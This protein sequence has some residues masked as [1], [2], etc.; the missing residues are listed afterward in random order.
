MPKGTSTADTRTNELKKMSGEDF[1]V[2]TASDMLL[3]PQAERS[4]A[5]RVL[6][7]INQTV[8]REAQPATR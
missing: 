3:L 7:A 8:D 5:L 4:K 6:E 2:R 1:A